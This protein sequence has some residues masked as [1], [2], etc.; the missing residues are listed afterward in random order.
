MDKPKFILNGKEYSPKRPT[1]SVWRAIVEQDAETGKMSISE[2]L[3]SRVEI[4]SWIYGI[5][6]EIIEA[7]ID[8]ADVLPAY[9]EA[10]RWVLGLVF[11]KL[12]KIPN[13]GAGTG[14]T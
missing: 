14:E 7:G 10:A 11:E 13:A 6:T 8:I 4:L 5:D 3:Q 2:I 12:D 1:M 9:N